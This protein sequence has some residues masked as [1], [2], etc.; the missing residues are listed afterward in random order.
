M[1]QIEQ[2]SRHY[3]TSVCVAADNV[4]VGTV[5]GGLKVYDPSSR[6]PI[7]FWG[8]IEKQQVY[9]LLNVEE[10]S[11]VLVLAR[12][13]MYVFSSSILREEFASLSLQVLFPN[14]SFP[15]P[16]GVDINEGVVIPPTANMNSGEVWVCSQS[17][18]GFRILHPTTFRL[19][20][21]VLY[22]ESSISL[23]RR[24]RHIVSMVVEGRSTLVF[25]DRCWIQKW[26]VAAREKKEAWDCYEACKHI[27][28]DHSE[29]LDMSECMCY[30]M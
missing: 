25:A 21:E 23:G 14:L 6:Q 8:E 5:K 16:S 27:Y 1:Q 26:D 12:K 11:S 3:V 30:W 22:P 9:L 4:W 10:S 28:G 7:A 2:S 19:K 18:L 20:E 24:I 15:S 17:G 29:F 13:G